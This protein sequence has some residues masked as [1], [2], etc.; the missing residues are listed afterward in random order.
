MCACAD[1]H[2]GDVFVVAAFVEVVQIQGVINNLVYV[3]RGESAC[4]DFEFKH[5]DDRAKRI[6]STAHARNAELEIEC[7]RV[8]YQHALKDFG[9][10]EPRVPLRESERPAGQSMAKANRRKRFRKGTS[11]TKFPQAAETSQ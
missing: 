10:L 7:A 9:L 1:Q 4:A 6:D 11:G 8:V 2:G 5:E 3:L